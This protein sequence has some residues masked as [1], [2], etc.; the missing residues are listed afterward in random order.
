[1]TAPNS[2]TTPTDA[3]NRLSSKEYIEKLRGI[4]DKYTST[5]FFSMINACINCG[6]CAKA[7]HYYCSEKEPEHIPANRIKIL[8][9]IISQYFHP[10][11]SK[12]GLSSTKDPITNPDFDLLYKAAFENCTICGNC[13]LACPMGI[14]TGEIM[15]MARAL[16]FGLGKLPSG[17]I[18][19]V[20]TAL[21]IGNYL[22]LSKED[23]IDT[24]EW[25]AEEME[26]DMGE[27]FE[28]PIDK[29]D[30]ETL[31]VPHPLTLRDLPFLLM[32]ELKIL[33][34]AKESYTLST[35][36]FDVAN[37]AFYQ[38]SKENAYHVATRPLEARKI[39]NANSITLA[40]CGH[41]YRVL[42]H[43]IEKIQGQ[44]FD[45]EIYTFVEL[46]D[47]YVQSGR[48]KLKKDLFEGPVTYHDPCNIGRRGGVI[49]PPRR[50]IRELTT[51]FVEMTPTG[52]HNYCC[53]GGGGLAST[54]DLGH[55]RQRMGKI[56]AEQIKRTGAKT[57]ITG[58]FNCKN[59][60][61]DI[62][63]NYN[64]DFQ[65]KSIV[66]VVANSIKF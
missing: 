33:E 41:G 38:G 62:A 32:D 12:I 61:R 44:R 54:G 39:A 15:Y 24:I 53:G 10:I 35:H 18:G 13:A 20:N 55:I 64:I 8:K 52:V 47:Q 34:A 63:E 7:C 6:A 11:K 2:T 37:Y 19:P 49:E 1:M 65:V 3:D 5:K 58:C 14:N 40:P 9:K 46:I 23:F 60:I 66:E 59:Q 26:D 51:N 30:V 29:K 45:F 50:V 16:L 28:L 57:V 25:L 4:F 48:I 21:E 43:E 17:L 27:G 31:Y 42:K 56:K 22:G 36:G